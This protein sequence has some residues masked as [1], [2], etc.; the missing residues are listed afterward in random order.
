VNAL[1]AAIWAVAFTTLGYI[2]GQTVEAVFGEVHAIEHKI[3]W[4]LA[5]GIV[6]FA[7][8][9]LVKERLRRSKRNAAEPS[10]PA[11]P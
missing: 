7:L 3:G 5:I 1:S 9:Q 10:D 8:Y 2:L 11:A 4:A 6:V